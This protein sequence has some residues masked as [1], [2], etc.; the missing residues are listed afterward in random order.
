MECV[1][2]GQNPK[3]RLCQNKSASGDD[4]FNGIDGM[5]KFL[6]NW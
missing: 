2:P 3:I 6:V 4:Q 5:G 1:R